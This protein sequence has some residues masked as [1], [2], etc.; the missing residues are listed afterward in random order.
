MALTAHE[1]A[2]RTGGRPGIRD[3]SQVL[4]AI[5]RPYHGYHRHIARKAAALLDGV[6]TSHGFVDGNKRT[7]I[8]LT[9]LMLLYSGYVLAH[10]DEDEDLERAIEDFAVAVVNH[11]YTFDEMVEWFKARITRID[12]A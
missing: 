2:L 12:R 9:D 10:A 5:A 8:I 4:S 7:A 6:A 3:W 11:E 1:V